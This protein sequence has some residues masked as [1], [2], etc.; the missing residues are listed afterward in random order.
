MFEGDLINGEINGKGKIFFE[1]GSYYIGQ[2]KK[3]LR[4][5]KGTTYY[6]NGNIQYEGDWRNGKNE[7]KG[8]FY[9]NNGD[10][11]MGDYYN[12]RPIGKHA[13]LTKN[14][15]VLTNYY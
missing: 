2:W 1:D 4:N 6:S 7:G 12:D 13:Y 11:S 9:Y 3:G 5:G 14:G 10:R 15:E 8:I